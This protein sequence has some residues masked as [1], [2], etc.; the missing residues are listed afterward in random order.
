[1]YKWSRPPGGCCEDVPNTVHVLCFH[2]N[3]AMK[4]SLLGRTCAITCAEVFEQVIPC[5]VCAGLVSQLCQPW[6]AFDFVIH[7]NKVI[8]YV[9]V[10]DAI[11]G[12]SHA[13]QVAPDGCRSFPS[14]SACCS[15]ASASATSW[16][17]LGWLAILP[18]PVTLRVKL[19]LL[20]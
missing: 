9:P 12:I 8:A 11:D 18:S 10:E 4:V 20:E 5:L 17:R 13:L 1:M 6:R 3:N 14:S 15:S 2:A 16:S 19:E 7:G